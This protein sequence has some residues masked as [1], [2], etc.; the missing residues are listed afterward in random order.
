MICGDWY[1]NIKKNVSANNHNITSKDVDYFI[2]LCIPSNVRGTVVGPI[3]CTKPEKVS[4]ANVTK[5]YHRFNTAQVLNVYDKCNLKWS[6]EGKV[7]DM[8]N[9]GYTSEQ[10]IR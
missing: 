10:V 6:Q 4:G 1:S 5:I 2:P 3:C 9:D 7:C 8:K